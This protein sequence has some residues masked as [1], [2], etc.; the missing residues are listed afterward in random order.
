GTLAAS[1][2]E[3]P[4]I[5]RARPDRA[6]LLDFTARGGRVLVLEQGAY[7]KGLFD[8]ELAE[9]RST[10]TFPLGSHHPALADVDPEDLKFW[11]GD[12]MVTPAEPVRPIEGGCSAIVVSGSQAGLDYAPLLERPIGSGT[13]VHSQLK[14]VEKFQ[15]EPAAA[16]ILANLIA[17]LAEFGPRQRKTGVIGSESYRKYLGSLGLRFDD[18]TGGA[19]HD[20]AG[21]RLLAVRDEIPEGLAGGLRQ[22][23]E[24]GGNL[25]V[26]RPSPESFARLSKTLDLDLTIQPYTGPVSLSEEEHA[27][28]GAI[29]REDLYWLGRHA[30]IAWAETPRADRMTDGLFGMALEGREF[31]T[32]EVEDWKR[33][34]AIVE[35]RAPGITFATVGSAAGEVEFPA[36]GRYLF[37]IVARGTPADGVWPQCRVAI[38]GRQV[39]VVGVESEQW[40]TVTCFGRVEQGRH[41]LSV[42]FIN[43]GG[44]AAKSEDRNLYVD[45]VLV[46]RDE[47]S[48]TFFLTNP[49]AVAVV[50]RGKGNVVLDLIRWD[51]EEQNSRKAARYACS[52]LT[53]LG[54]DFT[55]RPGVAIECE[56]MMPQP[57]MPHFQK[58]GGQ[59][60]LACSGY[61]EGPIRVAAAGRYTVEILASGTKAQEVYPEVELRI[62]GTPAGRVQLKS[63]GWSTFSLELELAEGEHRLAI[64][65]VNDM[66]RDGEDRNLMLDRVVFYRHG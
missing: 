31:G 4:V 64:A 3:Q 8:L 49:A 14:L 18:P 33:E 20:L 25:L 22:F 42:A 2:D 37:G 1:P 23:V 12:H 9:H 17:Y 52:L 35:A 13:M 46:A 58:R 7:P 50:P 43:D 55:P 51:T 44:S 30:G 29:A 48:S 60:S 61:I 26:H 40:Q 41:E 19:S 5:G 66:Q 59:V 16:R 27:L 47:A 57:G 53:A 45:K 56:T 63:D 65:F 62:D 11:R 21:Y 39:G 24:R 28:S 54:G 15:S 32:H 38:D 6:A 34:G 10:M 36:P